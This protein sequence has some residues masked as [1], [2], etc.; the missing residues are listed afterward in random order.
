[1]SDNN[2]G[3]YLGV[4]L[5]G[6]AYLLSQSEGGISGGGLGET[7][8]EQIEK[9]V[10][11]PQN[12]SYRITEAIDKTTDNLTPDW[13]DFP[14][15][16]PDFSGVPTSINEGAGN[17]G[18]GVGGV[19][20]SAFLNGFTGLYRGAMAAGAN[21]VGR[22]DV[23]A[24]NVLS[25]FSQSLGY[26]KDNSLR[27]VYTGVPAVAGGLLKGAL[28]GGDASEA[29]K[30]LSSGGNKGTGNSKLSAFKAA[31]PVTIGNVTYR[32]GSMTNNG[33]TFSG[34]DI[35]NRI[36]PTTAK[37]PLNKFTGLF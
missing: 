23:N 4:A 21:F 5:L 7:F 37:N 26:I 13:P 10:A 31:S 3:L 9:I 6:G 36:S 29:A 2:N 27:S 16:V 22:N 14:G 35:V 1:M 30:I 12:I 18:E 8:R 25:E 20:G 28:M 11:V 17:V 34:K 19:L 33:V 15:W 24:D 32:P